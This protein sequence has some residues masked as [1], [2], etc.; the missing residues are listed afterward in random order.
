MSALN[1]GPWFD[2]W[3]GKIPW[4]RKWQ[5]TPVLLTRKFHGWRRLVGYRPWSHKESDTTEWLHFT[6]G[7]HTVTL[8]I[9]YPIQ[10]QVWRWMAKDSFSNSIM[11]PT[12]LQALSSHSS[13]HFQHIGFILVTDTSWIQDSCQFSRHHTHQWPPKWETRNKFLFP[14]EALT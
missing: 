9:D 2:P 4:R 12:V 5:S 6:C 13:H 8:S 14:L 3:D 1:V 10:Q 7:W 11:L